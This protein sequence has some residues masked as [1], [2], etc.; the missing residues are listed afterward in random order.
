MAASNRSLL[1]RTHAPVLIGDITQNSFY[2]KHMSSHGRHCPHLRTSTMVLEKIEGYFPCV[3]AVCRL[4]FNDGA[5]ATPVQGNEPHL[6]LN[7]G[8]R[9]TAGRSGENSRVGGF[10]RIDENVQVLANTAKK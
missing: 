7:P 2:P 10:A 5:R 9:A 6:D 8:D 4:P 3:P 1:T